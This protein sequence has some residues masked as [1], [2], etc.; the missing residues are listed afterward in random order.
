ML[1]LLGENMVLLLNRNIA[2]LKR[3]D[4]GIV[5]D[6]LPNLVELPTELFFIN[7]LRVG[8]ANDVKLSIGI[9][10]HLTRK[11]NPKV[12]ERVFVLKRKLRQSRL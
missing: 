8:V 5:V 12:R 11:I 1:G 7:L 9:A 3:L 10:R 2:S 4:I 6:A